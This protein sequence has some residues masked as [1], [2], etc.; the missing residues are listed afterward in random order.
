MDGEDVGDNSTPAFI[1]INNDATYDIF[2]GEDAG[3]FNYY[4]NVGLVSNPSFF[5]LTG[6]TGFDPFDGVDAGEGSTITFVDIDGDSDFDAF[7]GESDG[8]ILYY[9][10]TGS[11]ASATFTQRTGVNNPFDGEDVGD[12]SAPTFVDIDNDGDFDAFIGEE[13]GTINY[14]ENQTAVTPSPGGVSGNLELWLKADAGVTESSGSVSAW[15]DQGNGGNDASQA[16]SSF[17]PT[18]TANAHN[19]NPGITFANDY[20]DTS[21][22]IDASVMPDLTVFSVYKPGNSSAGP[23][24][25][26]NNSSVNNRYLMNSS[27]IYFNRVGGYGSSISNLF[28]SG[29]TTLTTVVYDE[30]AS[31]GSSVYIDGTQAVTFTSNLGGVTGGTLDIG[32]ENYWQYYA[33]DIYEVV[34]YSNVLTDNERDRVHTYLGLKYGIGLSHDYLASDGT[35]I[36]DAYRPTAS[37]SVPT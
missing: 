7:M 5:D 22:N 11:A 20:F 34:M 32:F 13:D 1:D 3:T 21:L 18:Y 27:S 16:T 8:S 17:W 23:I 25:G 9:E 28:V 37:Y 4:E 26:N 30:D 24:W 31:S 6:F 19:Y 14:Y 29:Q 15:A 35:T 10:N 2:S 33:G 12:A 36:W